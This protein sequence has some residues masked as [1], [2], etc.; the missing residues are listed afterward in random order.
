MTTDFQQA[1]KD[2]P[3]DFR[4]LVRYM[5]LLMCEKTDKDAALRGFQERRLQVPIL[6][7]IR[8]GCNPG[9]GSHHPG[10]GRG[11]E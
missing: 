10:G 6:R 2:F 8:A 9:G 7:T 11:K 5:E 1:V 3:A 4:I